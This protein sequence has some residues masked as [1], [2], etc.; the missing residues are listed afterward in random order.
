MDAD[1]QLQ[2]DIDFDWNILND[3]SVQSWNIT[4]KSGETRYF[5]TWLWNAKLPWFFQHD[6]RHE[7][8]HLPEI[9]EGFQRVSLPSGFSHL[10]TNDGQTWYS[11]MKFLRDALELEI[12]KI[13]GNKPLDS[14]YHLW[15]IGKSYYD[16]HSKIDEF[17]FKKIHAD[18]YARRCIFYFERY[19]DMHHG[20]NENK[21]ASRYDDMGYYA[22]ILS[23]L[24]NIF[25]GNN[26]E[27]EN[28]LR[29]SEEFSPRRNEHLMYL[30]FHLDSIGSYEEMLKVTRRALS[31]E[32]I[33]PF[34]ETSFLI[35]DRA[36]YNT[37]NLFLELNEKAEYNT[38]KL[39]N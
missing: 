1:E 14:S 38:N 29:I 16:C 12:D 8:I 22:A 36:Y 26:S 7:T 30:A 13:V 33:N 23:G 11:P 2:V 20:W 37:S 21:K 34:P 24:C 6:K 28:Y 19:L 3:T 31:P 4:A 25:I 17:P 15:Y 10:I 27:G 5:R 18:E 39:K 32:R 9:G 35:D